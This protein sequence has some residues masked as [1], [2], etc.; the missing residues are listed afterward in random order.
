M[1]LVVPLAPLS[2]TRADIRLRFDLRL[3]APSISIL[4]LR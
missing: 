1:F 2:A 4:R 3:S